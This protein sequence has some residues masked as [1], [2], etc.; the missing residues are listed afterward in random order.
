[1][2]QE[3]W[4][5]ALVIFEHLLE[6]HPDLAIG[7]L[8]RSLVQDQLGE[9]ADALLDRE[10]ATELNP[11]LADLLLADFKGESPCESYSATTSIRR[12]AVVVVSSTPR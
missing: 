12:S 9:T 3:R 11:E 2:E 5:Q 6:H 8:M 10:R 7:H 4:D 1:M